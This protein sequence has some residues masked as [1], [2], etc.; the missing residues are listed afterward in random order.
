MVSELQI[1]PE[2][3][4]SIAEVVKICR[5][6]I[7]IGTSNR[8]SKLVPVLKFFE[9]IDLRSID[10]WDINAANKFIGQSVRDNSSGSI[11]PVEFAETFA[12]IE[13]Y[14]LPPFRNFVR[15]VVIKLW[16]R[17]LLIASHLY[18]APVNVDDILD[19]LIKGCENEILSHVRSMNKLSRIEYEGNDKLEDRNRRANHW[20]RLLL[21]T[22]FY[23]PKCLS[24][25]DVKKLLEAGY[26]KFSQLGRYYP[27]DFL[28]TIASDNVDAKNM[29]SSHIR[30]VR[31]KGK[32]AQAE[33]CKNRGPR[34]KGLEGPGEAS[35]APRNAIPDCIQQ[36][37]DYANGSS[38]DISLD[39]LIRDVVGTSKIK[40]VFGGINADMGSPLYS[41]LPDKA[42]G[43]CQLVNKTFSSFVKAQALQKGATHAF[44]LNLIMFYISVCL[45]RFYLDRD[46][47]L[48][49]YPVTL[50]DF[51]CPYYVTRDSLLDDVLDFE[52][53]PPITLIAF[54]NKYAEL[55]EW[56]N[57]TH[58]P[59]VLYIDK[60]FSYIVDNKSLLPNAD[61]VVN[62]FTKINYPRI[63]KR[64][65]TAKKPLP[66]KYFSTFVS[67]LYTLECLVDHVNAMADGLI[68]GS[69]EG[70]LKYVNRV[71]LE[72]HHL[73]KGL[74]GK[75]GNV[76]HLLDLSLLNYTPI[77]LHEGKYR[78]LKKCHRF[79]TIT[80][81]EEK[82]GN[83]KT[84]ATPHQV[85]ATLL[86]CETGI[87]QKHLL[88]LDVNRYDCFVDRTHNH[89]LAP[90][91]VNTDKAH[92]EWTAIVS[93][94]VIKICDRQREFYLNC[95]DPSFD[96]D[97]WYGEKEGSKFGRFKP[98]FRQPK[99]E[100]GWTNNREFP[101]L[102]WTL[103]HIIHEDLEESDFPDLVM[104]APTAKGGKQTQVT[105][106]TEESLSGNNLVSKHTPHALRAGFVS[107]AIRF[108]PPSL[109]GEYM[110]GQTEQLV[111]YYAVNDPSEFMSHQQLL[112][113]YIA[114]NAEAISRGEAP[115]LAATM[116]KVNKKL[117]SDI[118][119]N[120]AAAVEK[121]RLMSLSGI[122]EDK[123]GL[124]LILAKKHTKLAFNPTHICPFDN[125]CPKEVVDQYGL[126]RPHALCP[127][128]VRGVLH[129]PAV[130]A[131]KDK[132]R[133]FVVEY[134][135]KIKE[136][137]KRSKSA[138]NS[139]EL[140]ELNLSHD[141]AFREATALEA[142]E[143]QLYVLSKSEDNGSY[144]V[145]D[146][147][148]LVIHF[149]R[150]ELDEAEHLIKRMIDINNF[151]NL[152]SA[153]INR[154]IAYCRKKML[155][156]N[157]DLKGLLADN[158]GQSEAKLLTSQIKSM[159]DVKQLKVKDIFKIASSENQIDQNIA[160]APFMTSLLLP[161]SSRG[162]DY[163]GEENKE[164]V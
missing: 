112:A 74:W 60:Y 140:E 129:L 108:L 110:T 93:S 103:Q 89:L 48:D 52:K 56:T 107:E 87:R 8:N 130:S 155:L 124:K 67:L 159:M 163:D 134:Q 100:T 46:G 22:S 147:D 76:P 26:G 73:W 36:C 42:R 47:S 45:P 131:A 117:M 51:Q 122:S 35:A 90:L 20:L 125:K 72:E 70:N 49:E 33:G 50:N 157:S 96:D 24:G 144:I 123:S 146:R 39:D 145:Q 55:H 85:R 78:P 104:F 142:I 150:V 83:Q 37:L 156:N 91:L 102:L 143:Q 12:G 164:T 77:Y 59:R 132:H 69:I 135:E 18:I 95:G 43:F 136:Y 31:E 21:N 7:P 127:Y 154:K 106:Y 99:A 3:R 40:K 162:E 111:W 65:G 10:S 34:K 27:A 29:V 149:K 23:E 137:M 41:G 62:T 32:A 1:G 133:E 28:L 53:E 9:S 6:F 148:A 151:P 105:D 11:L 84:L 19:E 97:L 128:A 120:P 30:E 115:E 16:S 152:D 86:M 14:N 44:C 161:G 15:M 81:F 98:L 113:N 79:Y 13:G 114:K 109:V 160:S 75:A 138:Q 119:V 94:R 17:K 126:N 5:K 92:A 57:H 2:I 63:S 101:K 121:Y 66:R 158:D 118:E 64:M 58:Y 88:W 38:T 139:S 80:T 82:G 4:R 25:E 141:N 116:A 68:P 153:T 54:V 71:E 61:K